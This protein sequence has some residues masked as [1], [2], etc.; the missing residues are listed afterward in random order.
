MTQFF[1]LCYITRSHVYQLTTMPIFGTDTSDQT[2]RFSCATMTQRTL[3]DL[4]TK[5][6]GQPV[7]VLGHRLERKGTEATFEVF[8]DRL[9]IILFEDNVRLGYDPIELLLPTEIDDQGVAYFEIRPCRLCAQLFPLTADECDADEEP[10]CCP[11]C[12][13]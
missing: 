2:G 1:H 6:K 3:K 9:A 11:E 13:S 7:F 10:S 4:R 8:N 5:R 12:A